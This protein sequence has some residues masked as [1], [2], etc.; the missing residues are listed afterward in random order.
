MRSH[1]STKCAEDHVSLP[2][3][4]GEGGRDEECQGEVETVRDVSNFASMKRLCNP[5]VHLRPVG[6][7][8]ETNADGT[9]LEREH[10]GAVDPANRSPCQSVD[11]DKDVA[12]RNDTFGWCATNFPTKDIIS[13]KT[14]DFIFT[15]RLML[16]TLTI[17]AVDRMPVRGHDTS[18]G[19]VDDATDNGTTNQES[20]AA[21]A[22]ND[23][24]DTAGG[25]QEDHVLNDGRGQGYI[26]TLQ[27]GQYTSTMLYLLY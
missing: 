10:L 9:V 22:V 1:H 17:D 5:V 14:S 6:S 20:S 25:H 3:D 12:E 19:E 15:V 24:K 27:K 26:S 23:G 7:G 4:I 8:R 2:L 21:D 11:S 18:S 13:W 16:V